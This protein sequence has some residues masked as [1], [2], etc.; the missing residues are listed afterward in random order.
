MVQKSWF[1]H[2]LAPPNYVADV[3]M[4]VPMSRR[5]VQATIF[6][7][8][9]VRHPAALV[10][11]ARRTRVYPQEIPSGCGEAAIAFFEFLI[12]IRFLSITCF[13]YFNLFSN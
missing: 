8:H 5:Q 9:S 10:L 2:R 6:R 1:S 12:T 11:V 3:A 4:G 7:L 13:A